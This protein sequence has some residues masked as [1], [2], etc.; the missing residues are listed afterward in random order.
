MNQLIFYHSV[1]LVFKVRQ[2]KIPKYMYTMHNSWTYPYITRQAENG[3][4][5]VGVRPR[6]EVVRESFRWRA[7]NSFNQLPI[8]IRTCRKL[9]SFKKKVKP[10]IMEHISL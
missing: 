9:E 10:W 7:A 5:R 4:I 3:I 8:E 2:D 1:L 6:L